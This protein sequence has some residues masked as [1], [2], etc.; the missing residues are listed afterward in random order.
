MLFFKSILTAFISLTT[1]FVL[2]AQDNY[3]QSKDSSSYYKLSE[4]VVTA[5]RT[6]TSTL[7][8]ANS[9]SV[10]D[11]SEIAIKNKDNIFDLLNDVPG[12][13]L[14]SQGS[15]GSLENVFIRGGNTD[16]T[17]VLID[18]IEMNMPS[19]P[20]NTFD[21]AN[22]STDNI[23]RIEVLRGPQSTLYGSDAMAG[24]INIITKEGFGKPKFYLNTEGGSY[25][26]YKGLI[27]ANG[28]LNLLHYSIT[29]S[30]I[31][32]DGFSSASSAYGNTE[33]DG[34][35]DYNFSS[36][37]ALNINMNFKL[38]FFGRFNNSD[39]DYDQHGGLF[40][41]DPTYKY[42]SEE[43][44]YR[45]QPEFSLFDSKW[46]QILGISFFRNVRTYSFDSTLNNPS[47]SSSIYDGRKIKFD[48]QNNLKIDPDYLLTLGF[49][50]EEEQAISDYFSYT[51]GFGEFTSSFPK[52]SSRTSG[53][54][55]Q[56]QFKTLNSLFST[57]GIRFDH[58][59][60]FGGEVTYRIAP[61]YIFWATGTKLKFTYGTGFKA[62]SLF[63]LYDPAFGNSELKP[64]K[65]TGWD[66]GFE[67]YFWK[68]KFSIGFTYFSNSF[69]DLF[70]FDSNF[71]EVNIN[72]AKTNGIEFS[73]KIVPADIFSV[74]GSFTYTNTKDLSGNS[75]DNGLPL[76]RRPKIN[77]S[78]SADFFITKNLNANSEIIFVGERDDKNFNPYPA[79]RVKLPSYSLVNLAVSY[80]LLNQVKIYTRISNL[81]NQKYEEVYGYGTAG[82]SIY[83]GL[84]ITM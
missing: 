20:S 1:T 24:V 54:Y 31:K 62:P 28:S 17:L 58:H 47:S 16:H 27:G 65:N 37:L 79:V 48:W 38:K 2:L 55:L 68:S 67:Q 77:T 5:T 70:G 15:F 50:T 13:S 7:E 57:I 33:K 53:I 40:G 74:N 39:A 4:V 60:K 42:K 64:E 56:G 35:S 3:G 6:N 84:K 71:R 14:T 26:T 78:I 66:A 46:N 83:A 30:R 73:F 10:I 61:A 22:L 36:N 81:F 11:S 72:K 63:Y 41:D 51:S 82:F 69:T 43:Q 18:G 12:I 23:K 44:T 29:A 52:N 32:T 19:D 34:Y 76:L 21:F 45:I 9:I 25:N 8:L 75:T 80:Q 49:E 59:N